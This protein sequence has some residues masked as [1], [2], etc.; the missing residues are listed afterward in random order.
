[1]ELEISTNDVVRVKF[2]ADYQEDDELI[3][4]PED[5]GVLDVSWRIYEFIALAIPIKHVH[6]P[7]KC[8]RAMIDALNEHLAT[9]SSDED[10][11]ESD[12]VADDAPVDPR[13]A[14]L[15]KLIK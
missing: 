3:T 14:E 1:M 15:K 13:W 4:I 6:A 7:G 5:D 9:R 2:G 12:E 10:G 11:D 8:N